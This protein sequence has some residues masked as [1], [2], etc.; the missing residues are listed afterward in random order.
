MKVDILEYKFEFK[1]YNINRNIFT[2]TGKEYEIDTLLETIDF[3]NR[4]ILKSTKTWQERGINRQ[5][6]YETVRL[7]LHESVISK[8]ILTQNVCEMCHEKVFLTKAVLCDSC[9]KELCY[10]CDFK[11]HSTDPFH[12]RFLV[13]KESN[14]S[15][16]N[17]E[18]FDKDWK[19]V[20]YGIYLTF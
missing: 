4:V 5:N 8:Y 17:N 16:K 12:N 2:I 7:D 6:N 19:A 1:L 14:E 20:H 3:D 9:S 18:F 13:T 15:L 10:H 11:V